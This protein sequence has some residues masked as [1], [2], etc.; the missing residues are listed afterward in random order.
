MN[1]FKR[2]LT[3]TVL[4]VAIQS[5]LVMGAERVALLVGVSDYELSLI[6]I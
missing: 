6:H 5:H 3:F 1:I 2:Y 4:A